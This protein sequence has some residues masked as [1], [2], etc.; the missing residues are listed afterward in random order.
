MQLHGYLP[1]VSMRYLSKFVHQ[2]VR[3][4][5]DR[6]AFNISVILFL[7]AFI[8]NMA[9]LPSPSQAQPITCAA[10]TTLRL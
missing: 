4:Q 10:G 9:D 5:T 7:I 1:T 6:S 2:E 3:T 8:H